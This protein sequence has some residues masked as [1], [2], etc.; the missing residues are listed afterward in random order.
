MYG[1]SSQEREIS[2]SVR[3]EFLRALFIA[4]HTYRIEKST[5]HTEKSE[6][7]LSFGRFKIWDNFV[8]FRA[9]VAF[10]R[11]EKRNLPLKKIS[12]V[13]QDK[14]AKL[15]ISGEKVLLEFTYEA[16]VNKM[17]LRASVNQ[18]RTVTLSRKYKY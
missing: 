1:G 3:A 10:T 17:R 15:E 4:K 8:N 14:R 16:N 12:L 11:I 6:Y 18:D 7:T 5:G 2:Y 13:L 9:D